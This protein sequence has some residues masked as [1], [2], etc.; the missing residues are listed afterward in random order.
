MLSVAYGFI[1]SIS[2]G[3]NGFIELLY[4]IFSVSHYIG[5]FIISS[6]SNTF[7]YTVYTV[8]SIW[9]AVKILCS[10]FHSF[11]TD[12]VYFIAGIF[13]LINDLLN[14][15]KDAIWLLLINSFTI[16]EYLTTIIHGLLRTLTDLICDT[17]GY[18]L[19]A[20][21]ITKTSL[22]FTGDSMW[23]IV[24]S[25]PTLSCDVINSTTRS[26]FGFFQD[27]SVGSFFGLLLLA[28]LVYPLVFYRRYIYRLLAVFTSLFKLNL[29]ILGN[30]ELTDLGVLQVQQLRQELRREQSE[31]VCVICKDEP[32]RV[33]FLPC[34]HICTCEP[35]SETLL[36]R[37]SLCPLC[38]QP[39]AMSFNVFS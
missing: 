19:T 14:F 10:D 21:K 7:Q 2:A 16:F 5:H 9:N 35:C 22:V 15:L 39:I 20:L 34:K 38:R 28:F 8:D 37:N 30:S 26:V 1:S 27:V 17:F 25:I 11:L 31:K 4:T 12:N 33:I 32:K 3:L 24:K 29:A 23:H 36:S 6:L 18:S 13:K